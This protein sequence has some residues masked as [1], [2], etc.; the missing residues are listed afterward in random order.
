M[1]FAVTEFPNYYF[2]LS[3]CATSRATMFTGLTVEHHGV[4]GNSEAV[5][6]VAA[7]GLDTAIVAAL[8]AAGYNTAVLGKLLNRVVTDTFICPGADD[9]RLLVDDA[10]LGAGHSGHGMTYTNGFIASNGT[11]SPLTAGDTWTGSD[12]VGANNTASDARAAAAASGYQTD[13]MNRRGL[14]FLATAVEPFYLEMASWAPHGDAD[15]DNKPICAARHAAASFT[16]LRSEVGY[17]GSWNEADTADKPKWHRDT[18]PS[19][20][21]GPQQTYADEYEIEAKRTV[22]AVDELLYDV[23][24]SLTAS[25]RIDRTIVILVADNGTMGGEHRLTGQTANS[26]K[27][28]PYEASIH[29]RMYVHWPS[30]VPAGG[31]PNIVWIKMDDTAPHYWDAM[32][33]LQSAVT[34]TN[35]ALVGNID[36]APTLAEVG[37]AHLARRPDGMSYAPLLDGR[38]AAAN[39]RD[40]LLIQYQALVD[41][42]VAEM[43]T[44]RG[45]VKADGRKYI[46][47]DAIGGDPAETEYYSSAAVAADELVASQAA[48][49]D[50]EAAIDAMVAG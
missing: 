37:R 22:Q 2:N 45:V 9:S 28:V 11:L 35:A 50:L 43:P 29:N 40:Q 21:T 5:D 13:W 12:K 46:R 15:N 38:V 26:V 16:P 49:S 19:V 10:Y 36:H 32:A 41:S 18:V 14:N 25:G 39:F 1:A 44:W 6:W 31:R 20:M 8:K 47:Y 4:L 48:Q 3:V 24:R 27:N 34:A 42:S 7:G 33:Y 30:S 23:V 17:V